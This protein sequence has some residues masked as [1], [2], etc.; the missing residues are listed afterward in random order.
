MTTTALSFRVGT[1]DPTAELGFEAWLNDRCLLN[2]DWVKEP[3]Y[4]QHDFDDSVDTEHQLRFILKNKTIDHTKISDTGEILADAKLTVTDV[5]F[6]EIDLG[7]LLTE[8]S[9]Y[10]HNFNG[11]TKNTSQKFY[12]EMG[13]NGTV[14]FKFTTPIYIWLLE[15]M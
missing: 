11:T 9:V 7:Y 5:A 6:D 8:Y 1:T 3:V 4:F 14:D 15:H 13:C 2:L 10:T 12:S